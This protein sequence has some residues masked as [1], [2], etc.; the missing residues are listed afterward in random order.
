MDYPRER[1]S[2][3]FPSSL[4]KNRFLR[5]KIPSANRPSRRSRSVVIPQCGGYGDDSLFAIV[6]HVVPM[7]A[8][9]LTL[10]RFDF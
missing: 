7:K 2:E 4:L 3:R 10:M 6:N 5:F 1:Y 8:C 9:M